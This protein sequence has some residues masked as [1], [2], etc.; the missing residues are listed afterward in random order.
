MT[1]DIEFTPTGTAVPVDN[2]IT[3]IGEGGIS[4]RSYGST[5]IISGGGGV[6][7][8]LGLLDEMDALVPPDS[9][10]K[11]KFQGK[12][13]ISCLKDATTG[14]QMDV[15][16]S[17]AGPDDHVL[18]SLKDDADARVTA[19]MTAAVKLMGNH[20]ISCKKNA[21]NAHQL[22][23]GITGLGPDGHLLV[24]LKDDADAVVSADAMGSI[25]LKGE[26]GI[27]CKKDT[28]NANQMNIGVSGALGG[29]TVHEQ[30]LTANGSLGNPVQIDQSPAYN[31]YNVIATADA[32]SHSM[33][34]RLPSTSHY[35]VGTR[36]LFTL[37]ALQVWLY[38]PSGGSIRHSYANN[39]ANM[40]DHLVFTTNGNGP[41]VWTA[42]MYT[43]STTEERWSTLFGVF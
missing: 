15:G 33:Y 10:G 41:R 26:S 16:I 31:C 21:T 17:G 23:V 6:T 42:T 9:G 29:Y 43:L 27:T 11:I 4:V 22:D 35:P 8:F 37:Q 36:V 30:H 3:F 19:D 1:S 5:I 14:T 40:V 13:G 7:N 25:K 38:A 32:G 12:H 28:M 18:T 20:G 24:S 34:V 39:N 2:Q